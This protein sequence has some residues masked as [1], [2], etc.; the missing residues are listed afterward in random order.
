MPCRLRYSEIIYIIPCIFGQNFLELWPLFFCPAKIMDPVHVVQKYDLN[1]I[2]ICLSSFSLRSCA[3][4]WLSK[5]A[6]VSSPVA[7]PAQVEHPALSGAGRCR[8]TQQRDLAQFHKIDF[9]SK[10]GKLQSLFH[11]QRT[12]TRSVSLQGTVSPKS[13]SI[14]DNPCKPQTVCF[15]VLYFC[16]ESLPSFWCLTFLYF[17]SKMSEGE[18]LVE[19]TLH[20]IHISLLCLIFTTWWPGGK[21]KWA[22]LTEEQ[23]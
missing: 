15:L 1:V 3:E 8:V 9:L 23:N 5:V 16:P 19:S 22:R 17:P 4:Q 6:T 11:I 7:V 2:L 10:Q 21:G 18:D 14:G 12:W 20:C 13:S